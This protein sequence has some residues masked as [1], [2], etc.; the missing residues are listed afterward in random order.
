MQYIGSESEIFPIDD[1]EPAV[2]RWEK[3]KK[4]KSEEK[5]E[6]RFSTFRA[7]DNTSGFV[8]IYP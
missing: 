7:F 6:N 1:P 3:K 4:V 8:V 5:V 2:N